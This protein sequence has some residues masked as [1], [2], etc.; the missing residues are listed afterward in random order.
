[1][2]R[3]RT[4]DRFL[5]CGYQIFILER[6]RFHCSA[7][8]AVRKY[9]FSFLSGSEDRRSHLFFFFFFFFFFCIRIHKE[10]FVS[11]LSGALTEESCPLPYWFTQLNWSVDWSGSDV[12]R[13]SFFQQTAC[14][15]VHTP[16]ETVRNSYCSL[17]FRARHLKCKPWP[18]FAPVVW[19]SPSYFQIKSLWKRPWKSI[20]MCLLLDLGLPEQSDSHLA[21]CGFLTV[22]SHSDVSGPPSLRCTAQ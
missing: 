21:H 12:P 7:S 2:R 4:A 1:M 20:L 11:G 5:K 9:A 15:H 10:T 3:R 19:T 17:R 14:W 22:H 16:V 13:V 18:Q 8:A 6:K